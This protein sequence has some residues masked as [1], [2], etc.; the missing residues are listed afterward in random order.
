M[1]LKEEIPSY[2]DTLQALRD[3]DDETVARAVFPFEYDDAEYVE[4]VKTAVRILLDRASLEPRQIVA[5]GRALHG[6]ERLPLRT[7]GL[8]IEISLTIKGESGAM[9]WDLYLN[10]GEFCTDSSG[11]Q[12]SGYGSDAVSGERF[13][14]EARCREYTGRYLER[15]SWPDAFIEICEQPLTILDDCDD[16][17]L[18]W[19]HPSGGEFWE[20][21]AKYS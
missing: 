9:S 12:D 17:L 4:R 20:W 7:P 16:R 14:V 3:G 8:D 21:L 11:Y 2:D 6:L 13:S 19:D 10:S 15:E 18:D 5:I 1:A